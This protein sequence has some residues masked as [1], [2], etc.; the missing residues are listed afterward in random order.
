V[1]G[2]SFTEFGLILLVI[3]VV[4]GPQKLPSMMRTL[5]QWLGR[6]RRMTTE[7]RVQSGIDDVLRQEGLS[8]GLTELRA[9]VRGE[10]GQLSKPAPH[11]HPAS[12]ITRPDPYAEAFEP[13]LGREYPVEGP[14]AYGAL[15]ED[16][17]AL[18]SDVEADEPHNAPTSS[19]PASPK[20]PP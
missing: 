10:L 16:L 4:V 12:R 8:G 9:I 13:D 20:H 5:G 17:V 18:A 7:M 3:L 1:F 15:A 6:F 2:V 19:P 11:G 14:D